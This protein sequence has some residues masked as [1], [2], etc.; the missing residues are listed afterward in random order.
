M[1][2]ITGLYAALCG[3]LLVVLTLRTIR[4]RYAARVGI[5]DGGDA[6]LAR[7]IRVHANF[8]EYVPLALILLYL[9]EA[10]GHGPATVHGLG[11]ALVVGRIAHA[12]GFTRN[13]GASL[14]R[15]VGMVL[16]IAVIVIASALLLRPWL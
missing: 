9:V 6:D 5:G 10:S 2:H 8:T 11:S 4:R 7:R 16:T 13:V 3:L 12:I 1:T 15:F 14:P